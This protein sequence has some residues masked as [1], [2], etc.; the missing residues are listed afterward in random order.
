VVAGL[1]AG[2]YRPER[3]GFGAHAPLLCPQR[4]G[5]T[6]WGVPSGRGAANIVAGGAIGRGVGQEDPIGP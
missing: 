1:A 3:C 5:L 6:G 4:Y 2:G